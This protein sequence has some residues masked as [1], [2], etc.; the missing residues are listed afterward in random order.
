MFKLSDGEV[1]NLCVEWFSGA[2]TG[3]IPTLIEDIKEEGS[4]H[5]G[6]SEESR[7]SEKGEE[8]QTTNK[9][10]EVQNKKKEVRKEK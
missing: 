2:Q 5:H 10:V 8:I 7:D 3:R 9:R 6:H 1:L 4:T